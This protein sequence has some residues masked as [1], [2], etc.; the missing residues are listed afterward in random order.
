MSQTMPDSL[1]L[2]PL[3]TVLFPGGRLKLRIFEPRYVDLVSRSMREGSGFGICPIDEGTELE[4][5]SIC[6]IGSWVKVVDFETLEDGLLGV[7]VEADHRFDVGEQWREEDRLLH[8]EVNAL[9]T[10]DDYPVGEQWSGLVEL[11]EQLWP[12]MQREYGYG[13]W[14]KETGAYWLMS[15]LTEVL[16]VKSSIRAE[17]LACDE[18]EAGLRLVAE[19]VA[20]LGGDSDEEASGSEASSEDN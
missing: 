18:A 2:F 11:L 6:G 10:P 12:E 3:N 7:T 4:P 16:P 5:R 20:D 17:L 8:A 15:R 14:P 19:L 13:L 1:P 9:P